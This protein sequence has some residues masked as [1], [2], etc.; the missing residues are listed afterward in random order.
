MTEQLPLF[1]L[2]D[3]AWTPSVRIV[4]LAGPSG[5]GKTSLTKR[6]GLPSLSLDNF[7]KDEDNRP[8]PRTPA[9]LIDWD[10]PESW[11]REEALDALTSIALTGKA[12]VPI[13]D[14]PSNRRTG[15]KPFDAG[16]A[17]LV[18]AEG[19]FA[20]TLVEDLRKKGVLAGAICIARSPMRNAWFRLTR[21][22]G[23]ARKPVPIL[24]KRGWKLLRQEPAQVRKWLADGC[25]GVPSLGEA[26]RQI[27]GM[28]RRGS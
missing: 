3:G 1:P 4:V 11:L 6:L 20:S 26:E 24:I 14:I 5:S 13:Y 10:D 16:E 17:P 25:E 2:P 18:V 8:L 15:S 21:D 19:I 12:R 28:L 7:Y 22:L 9:G 23:E 27:R